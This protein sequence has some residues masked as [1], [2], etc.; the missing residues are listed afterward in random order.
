M[1]M[2]LCTD[3]QAYGL[4]SNGWLGLPLERTRLTTWTAS[5]MMET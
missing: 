2:F 5:H 4:L 3:W 1:I